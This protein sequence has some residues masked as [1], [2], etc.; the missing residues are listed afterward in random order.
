VIVRQ[1]VNQLESWHRRKKRFLGPSQAKSSAMTLKLINRLLLSFSA[2]L[3]TA[4]VGTAGFA[5]EVT[6]HNGGVLHG[7][8]ANAGKNVAVTSSQ[9]IRVVVERS[10]V[11][12][13]ARNTSPS[14]SDKSKLT[15]AEKAWFPKIR[16]LLAR[17]ENGDGESRRLA[18]H[19][20]RTINDPAAIP[21]LMQMLRTNGDDTSRLL[22]VR[23]LGDMPGSKAVV[24]LVEEALFD[25][26]EVVREAAQEASKKLRAEYVRPFY[27]QALQFPNREV[28]CRAATVLETVG[29]KENVPYLIDSLY[30]KVVDVDYRPSCCA[31]RVHYLMSPRGSR[32]VQDNLVNQGD[33][34]RARLVVRD[35]Q[36]PQVKDALEAITKQSFGY[37]TAAWKHWWQSEQLAENSSHR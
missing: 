33:H 9:G 7:K 22:Y 16:K 36:N 30:S 20:L 3:P 10:S 37:N 19:D 2:L 35:V 4:V 6:L 13:I 21:A 34:V 23:I 11:Q 32:Y 24:G 17:V 12:K 18:L 28:V 14:P 5:D 8:V 26:S 15:S 31:S 27:G 29:N 25:S 1:P